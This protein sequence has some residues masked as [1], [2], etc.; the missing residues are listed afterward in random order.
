M[1]LVNI[2]INDKSPFKLDD[3]IE[4]KEI[5]FILNNKYIYYKIYNKNNGTFSFGVMDIIL[6]IIKYISFF[7]CKS[8]TQGKP[9]QLINC[10]GFREI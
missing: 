5:N 6:N 10:Y 3:N 2:S 1:N 7:Y 4:I 9:K 8:V